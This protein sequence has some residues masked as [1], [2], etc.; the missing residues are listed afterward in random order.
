MLFLDMP[1]IFGVYSCMRAYLMK[2]R[3]GLPQDLIGEKFGY[4][5]VIDKA[6]RLTYKGKHYR[7]WL[8][9]CKCGKKIKAI[10]GKL[11]Y[12]V[13]TSCG[14]KKLQNIKPKYGED[15]WGWTG[16]KTVTGTMWNRI[17]H[18]AKRRNIEFN[19]TIEYIQELIEKQQ[20]KCAIS[21]LPIYLAR[22]SKELEDLINT[23]SL[24]RINSDK[25]YIEG[26]VQWVHKTIQQMKWNANE[27]S[28]FGMCKI[29]TEYQESLKK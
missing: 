19:I 16:F 20:Y 25:G 7:Q 26:N 14:C 24:D 29:I 10:T 9:E 2:K 6:E 11:N 21:G 3:T 15:H 23:A 17:K 22:S 28:F 27:E 12:G 13:I 4:L 1:F 18:G 5:K 8:C